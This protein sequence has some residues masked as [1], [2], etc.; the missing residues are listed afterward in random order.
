[1]EL[2]VLLGRV[3]NRRGV[4]LAASGTRRMSAGA[5]SEGLWERAFQLAYFVVR[6][7]SSAHE[8]VARAVEKLE[9]Q[10]SREKRRSYW[11]RRSKQLKIRRIS[12]S[13]EDMLQWLVC[14]E[15][16]A[17][18]K[19]Q[20][21]QQQPT[22]ADMV[23]RYVK[24][25]AQLT[26]STSSFHVNIGIN[27]LLR[28][29]S[30]PEVQQIY[31]L[32]TGQYPAAEEYRKAKGRLLNQLAVRFERFL[33]VHT[34][35]Y[36]ELRFE[37]HED[38]QPWAEL[39]EECL[40]TFAPWSGRES[41]VR[42]GAELG[43]AVHATAPQ[44]GRLRS[45]SDRL[46]TIRCH[47]FMH[48]TCYGRLAQ[49]LGFASPLERLSVPRFLKKD[50]GS[51]GSGPGMP[52]RR[53]APLS[54]GELGQL[55]ERVASV[56]ARRQPLP[57]EPIKIVA[58]GA[59]CARLNPA[60]DERR[61]FEIP[62]GTRLL[63]VR[64]GALDTDLILAAHWVD[65]DE[66]DRIVAG[67]YSIPLQGRRELV[68]KV[69]PSPGGR[70]AEDVRA[71]V[72]VESR[73][74]LP[75]AE[76]LGSVGSFFR[77]RAALLGAVFAGA[78]LVAVGWVA[79]AAYYQLRLSREQSVIG[80]M[81]AQ[82]AEQHATIASLRRA[83]SHVGEALTH[84][85]FTSEGSLRGPGNP[86]EPV[87]VFGP[88]E[89]LVVIELPATGG[90]QAS[91]RATLSSFPEEQERLRETGLRT[92]LKGTDRIVV[93]PLPAALVASDTHYLISLTQMNGADSRRFV[94]EVRKR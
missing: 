87:V 13:A 34:A 84:Y 81:T 74:V 29:Y 82:I 1:M 50:D 58:H 36:G 42:T 41:C 5:V 20:E 3:S 46:E 61:E 93:F 31:E 8:I 59:V 80:Q 62:G 18:E 45:M 76:W 23:I 33:R 48:S 10:R 78:S 17:C 4:A 12:R 54:S 57:L 63:E 44:G 25:L 65:Y 9:A 86:G 35:Q 26:T 40:E 22:E 83:P 30:T 2:A 28:N 64:S 68:F 37:T 55:R 43:A 67:E 72:V 24:H 11:R 19:E 69:V 94:F 60:T 7:R 92:V 38:H 16:E 89:S 71:L 66:H 73:A 21:A 39:V 15:S 6:D 51:H 47:W 90:E 56:V 32:A 88:G 79:M 27:R 70:G 75:V 49:Q 53:A 85:A 77:S 52:G 91:Y 14:L